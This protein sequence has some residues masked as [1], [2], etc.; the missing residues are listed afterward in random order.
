MRPFNPKAEA[1]AFRIWAYAE[2]LGWNCSILEISEALSV[3]PQRVSGMCQSKNWLQRLRHAKRVE[4]ARCVG[5]A[6]TVP[7]WAVTPSKIT[8]S[9]LHDLTGARGDQGGEHD[10]L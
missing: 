5:G 4:D 1:L 8:P 2:P 10:G 3:S 6:D 7:D 9:R